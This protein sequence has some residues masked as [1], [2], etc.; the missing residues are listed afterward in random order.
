MRR[1]TVLKTGL[2][3][4][5]SIASQISLAQTYP[6]RPRRA[7][8][9]IGVDRSGPLPALAGA[10]SGARQFADFLKRQSIDVVEFNDDRGDKVRGSDIYTAVSKLVEPGNLHQ[11]IIYFAGHGFLRGSN[12]YWLLSDAPVDPNEAITVVECERAALKTGIT[13]VVLI[14]DACRSLPNSLGA[15]DLHG[16]VIFPNKGGYDNEVTVDKFFATHPGDASFEVPVDESTAEYEGIFTRV[17]LEAFTNPPRNLAKELTNGLWV[18]PNRRLRNYLRERVPLRAQEEDVNLFQVP[19]SVVTSDEPWH[20][21]FVPQPSGG[22]GSGGGDPENNITRDPFEALKS[23]VNEVRIFAS[24]STPWEEAIAY[25]PAGVSPDTADEHVAAELKAAVQRQEQDIPAQTT[26]LVVYGGAI[27]DVFLAQGTA[28]EIKQGSPEAPDIAYVWPD[29]NRSETVL[30]QLEKGPAMPIPLIPGF[31]AHIHVQDGEIRDVHFNPTV[32]S[33]GYGDFIFELARLSYLRSLASEA[34][35]AGVLTF[36]GSRDEREAAAEA[37]AGQIRI[38]KDVDPVLGL[39]AAYAY[40]QALLFDGVGSVADIMRESLNYNLYDVEML[41]GKLSGIPG[42]FVASE[43]RVTPFCPL[44]R[45]G[46]ELLRV[47]Q[48]QLHPIVLEASTG[49]REGLWT[50]FDAERGAL[51]GKAIQEGNI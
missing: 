36:E 50:T 25:L 46:W 17:L 11:L 43:G 34:T 13:N 9:V 37:F 23:S 49:L 6:D 16:R 44:L 22:A 21:G 7:A 20:L 19:Q 28:S 3:F 10:A 15:N 31:A 51:I 18:I 40:S 41:T 48:V 5:G 39:Y 8:I 42:E 30:L 2:V 45:Q 35:R 33:G 4:F 47:N 29:F 26:G 24:G 1:R 12:E 32:E 38:L 14:S 27:E